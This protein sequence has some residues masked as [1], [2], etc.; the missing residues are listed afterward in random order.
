VGD[1]NAVKCDGVAHLKQYNQEH[2]NL[3]LASLR[4]TAVN[5]DSHMLIGALHG[6]GSLCLIKLSGTLCIPAVSSIL[7]VQ[8]CF[9]LLC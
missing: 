7:Y 6:Q 3:W 2:F 5:C 9:L 8:H 1:N 4:F